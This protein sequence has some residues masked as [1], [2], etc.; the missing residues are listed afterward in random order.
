MNEFATVIAGKLSIKPSQVDVVL[1]LLSEGSTIPFI[2]R[3]RK[4]KTGALDE[5]Q[6]QQIQDESKSLKE[7]TERKTLIE[8]TI[9]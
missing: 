9:T 7:S 6:I 1:D 4:D 2:A 5:V 8:K 3:Y